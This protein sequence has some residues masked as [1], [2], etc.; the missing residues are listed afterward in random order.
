[1]RDLQEASK[2]IQTLQSMIDRDVQ[3]NCVRTAGSHT[4]NLLRVRRGLDM[5]RLLFEQMLVAE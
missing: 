1:M 3:D 4:R 2:S 5:V